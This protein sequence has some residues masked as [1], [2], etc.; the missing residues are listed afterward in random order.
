MLAEAASGLPGGRVLVLSPLAGHVGHL[1][2]LIG[3]DGLPGLR[4]PGEEA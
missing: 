4:L 1:I 2:R 3:W